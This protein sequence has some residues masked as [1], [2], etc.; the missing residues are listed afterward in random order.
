MS[1]GRV[2]DRQEPLNTLVPIPLRSD[3]DSNEIDESNSQFEN[4]MVQELQH[5]VE[6][7]WIEVVK[8]NMPLIQFE[9]I[10]NLIQTKSMKVIYSLR[11]MITQEF[12]HS[13][14]FQ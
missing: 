5:F 4:R 6:F 7:E 13:V 14:E 1:Q 9:S 10:V 3:R 2:T 12:H 8:M 11:K